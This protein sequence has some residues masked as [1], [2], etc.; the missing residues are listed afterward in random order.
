[1][2]Y[3]QR[4]YV[5]DLISKLIRR[6]LSGILCDVIPVREHMRR[7][8]QKLKFPEHPFTLT[9]WK[10]WKTCGEI[11]EKSSLNLDEIIE[12]MIDEES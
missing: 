9:E 7:T 2:F 8:S 3:V 11:L 4:Q 6:T 1:M 12:E 5:A 10:D